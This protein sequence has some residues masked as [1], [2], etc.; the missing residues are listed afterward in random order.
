[1]GYKEGIILFLTHN[2]TGVSKYH[3]IQL[4]VI[5]CSSQTDVA[6]EPFQ[7][8]LRYCRRHREIGKQAVSAN[9]KVRSATSQEGHCDDQRG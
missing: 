7:N 8:G 2:K 6:T 1:M 5:K 9:Q 3:P 4:F